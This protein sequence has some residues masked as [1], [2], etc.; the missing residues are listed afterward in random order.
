MSVTSVVLAGGGEE[1][2]FSVLGGYSLLHLNDAAGTFPVGWIAD[3]A[4][5]P[6]VIDWLSFVCEASGN[7][8]TYDGPLPDGPWKGHNEALLGGSR[9]S[10]RFTP[11]L[12]LL[13]QV[14]L[15]VQHSGTSTTQVDFSVNRFSWAAG[16]GINID[17]SQHLGIRFEGSFRP[18]EPTQEQ[19]A[20]GVVFKP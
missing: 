11:R 6:F 7:Y 4:V 15:G 12:S 17:L 19:F 5:R 8:K 3:V 9:F 18:R 2:K 20:V 16:G 13:A 14:L 1:P 10:T